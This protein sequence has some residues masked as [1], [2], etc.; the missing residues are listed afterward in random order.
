MT[1]LKTGDKLEFKFG[2]DSMGTFEVGAL[3][4]NAVMMLVIHRHDQ[5]STAVSFESHV[6]ANMDNAQVAVMDTYKGNAK[7][8][9]KIKEAHQKKNDHSEELRYESVVAVSPGEYVL[10]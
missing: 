9:L 8:T 4:L 1:P 10:E 6:F 3:P 5:I 2:D 7:G